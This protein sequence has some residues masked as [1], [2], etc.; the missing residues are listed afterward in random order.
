M[1][2]RG[3]TANTGHE[4]VALQRWKMRDMENA[5]NAQ[6]GKQKVQ[7]HALEKC[8]IM[9]FITISSLFLVSQCRRTGHH[10]ARCYMPCTSFCAFCCGS[11]THATTRSVNGKH[12]AIHSTGNI[13]RIFLSAAL[14][15]W[16]RGDGVS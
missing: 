13:L 5:R 11:V 15:S 9:V 7:K 12:D 2:V 3:A 10:S 14:S 1:F 8:C 16:E 6:Y 4:I